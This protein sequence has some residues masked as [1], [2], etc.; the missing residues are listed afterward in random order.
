MKKLHK[1]F[2]LACLVACLCLLLTACGDSKD[3]FTWKVDDAAQTI[4][5]EGVGRLPE[6]DVNKYPDDK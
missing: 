2:G 4:T 3:G 1:T 6:V 5:V